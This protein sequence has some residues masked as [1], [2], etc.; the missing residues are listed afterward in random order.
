[1]QPFGDAGKNRAA[2]GAR[3]IADGDDVRKQF[4]GF[5]DIEDGLRFLLGNIDPHFLH[6]FDH[7]RIQRPGL[8]P[9]ALGVEKFAAKMIEPRLGHLAAGAVVNANEE[10]VRL[11]NAEV[12]ARFLFYRN[13]TDVLDNFL[14]GRAESEL[15]ERLR[16]ASWFAVCVVEGGTR[17]GP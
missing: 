13:E 2:L 9:G 12:A 14:P 16:Q 1:M 3:F 6:R 4:A 8:E 7:E 17:V 11:Q 5:E 10:N 15:D